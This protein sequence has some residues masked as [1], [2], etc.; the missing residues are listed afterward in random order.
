MVT[1]QLKEEGLNIDGSGGSIMMESEWGKKLEA[2][3]NN[4]EEDL[5]DTLERARESGDLEKIEEAQEA[6]EKF[7]KFRGLQK[8]KD[9][10]QLSNLRTNVKRRIVSAIAKINEAGLPE[11]S[12]Y[13]N[14]YI[15]TGASC[16]YTRDP[17]NPIDWDIKF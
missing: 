8:R 15:D 10:T 3:L 17:D 9:N 4:R 11:L 7:Q 16:E 13:L 12:D 6:L 14:I 2:E 1:D 5:E